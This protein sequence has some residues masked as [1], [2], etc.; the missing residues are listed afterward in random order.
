MNT[1]ALFI[2]FLSWLLG[3]PRILPG[4]EDARENLA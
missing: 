4:Q 1:T 3:H 2:L